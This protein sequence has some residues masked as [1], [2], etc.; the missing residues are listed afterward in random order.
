VDRKL[1]EISLLKRKSLMAADNIISV[2]LHLTELDL[3]HQVL[4]NKQLLRVSSGES[5]LTSAG[6]HH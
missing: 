1:F 4:S 6:L 5:F 2:E 3:T